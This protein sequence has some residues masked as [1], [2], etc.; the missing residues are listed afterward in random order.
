MPD[1]RRL[2]PREAG[3]SADDDS[4]RHMERA[5][6]QVLSDSSRSVCAALRGLVD[7]AELPEDARRFAVYGA[8]DKQAVDR[9]DQRAV[10]YAGV[11]SAARHG[12]R[13]QD[14]SVSAERLE[15]DPW[16]GDRRAGIQAC[17][18]RQGGR[19]AWRNTGVDQGGAGDFHGKRG[20]KF[21]ADREGHCREADIPWLRV[22]RA[23]A[24][25][26]WRRNP[27]DARKPAVP[28]LP[29]RAVLVRHEAEPQPHDG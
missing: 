24:V 14:H 8:C 5:H 10:D 20:V 7:A 13:E 19:A 22:A 6:A 21:G 23:G 2:L 28:L 1:V 12:Y 18:D 4:G 17:A 29:E 16:I 26:L 27:Q 9:Q 15:R 3:F 11:D 25:V